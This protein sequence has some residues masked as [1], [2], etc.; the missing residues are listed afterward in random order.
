M[1]NLKIHLLMKK[2]LCFTCLLFVCSFASAQ[3][4][5]NPN[6]NVAVKSG[7]TPLSTISV[8]GN[9]N[10]ES[11]VFV[12]STKR[13]IMVHRTGVAP[14]GG[15]GIGI[16]GD[17]TPEANSFNIGTRGYTVASSPLGG[18]R[19]YGVFG[20]AGNC[21]SGYN[22]GVLG[23]LD[24]S[25]NGA[26][27]YG[28]SNAYDWGESIP[29]RYAGF[30]RGNVYVT[31]SIYG[32][33][34]T[35]TVTSQQTL[36][37]LSRVSAADVSVTD[38][39]SL[40]NS[41]RYNLEQP[42]AQNVSKVRNA[43]DSLAISSLELSVEEAQAYSKAHYG[44]VAQELKEVYP[45]LVY[46]NAQGE[47]SIN[48][49][50]MIPLLVQ[51]IQELA[52]EVNNLKSDKGLTRAAVSKGGDDDSSSEYR[53][54]IAPELFQNMPNPFTDNT[55]IKYIIPQD[56]QKANL[57]IYNMSGKQ[58]EQFTLSQK[59]EGSVTLAGSQLEAG[60]YL[61]SLIVDG[62]VIDVKRMILTK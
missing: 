57:L 60:M 33:L 41:V 49:I 6:G 32:Q 20:R 31:G 53:D 12:E 37:P 7:V 48:Y 47:L 43:G 45:D 28:T 9:G 11:D 42:T 30:F 21:T 24:G 25:V 26:G 55:V 50:E 44:F 52:M 59:G 62:N 22:F 35:P 2:I 13:G 19:A 1:S 61:Y 14:N 56:A 8:N 54:I 46:E 36:S 51:S 58:I 4:T 17:A 40:L 29:G 5:V 39:L 18:G 15:W 3:L 10:T 23:A 34:L 16:T 38:K 27:I